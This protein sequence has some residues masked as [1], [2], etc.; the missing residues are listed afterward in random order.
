[1]PIANV[2]LKKG[3]HES[4]LS[5]IR[6][7]T[8]KIQESGIIQK[9][10]S[11]RYAKRDLSKLSLKKTALKRIAKRKETERLRKLGKI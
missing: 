5:I 9:V 6:R 1:M 11:N 8:R 2:E 7:F 4:N 3:P 10:K